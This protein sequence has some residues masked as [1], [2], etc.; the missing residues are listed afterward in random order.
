MSPGIR[1]LLPG[2]VP[3]LLLLTGTAR[4]EGDDAAAVERVRS[5]R[6]RRATGPRVAVELRG[7]RMNLVLGD[8]VVL[9]R[10]EGATG[11]P[12]QVKLGRPAF[13]Q[14]LGMVFGAGYAST[15][16]ISD[17]SAAPEITNP[18]TD[19]VPSATPGRRAPHL[20]VEIDGTRVST[21]DLGAGGFALVEAGSDGSRAARLEAAA[22]A[23]GI[24]LRAIACPD[25]SLAAAYG[26]GPGGLVLIRPD[27]HV[28]WRSAGAGSND[29]EIMSALAAVVA[30]PPSGIA[31]ARR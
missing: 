15:A 8:E 10:D 1:A 28:G 9:G 3:L 2:I 7:A 26:L 22:A 24:P 29:A 20:W 17:G 31:P 16:V 13:I 6:A 25:A 21:L 30:R 5:I 12:P 4:G 23:S 19:Y 18:V 27:G 14:E 11:G